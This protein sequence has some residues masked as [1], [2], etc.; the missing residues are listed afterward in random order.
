MRL[1]EWHHPDI[2]GGE[3]PSMTRTFAELAEVLETGD[4]RRYTTSEPANTD[5]RNWPMGGML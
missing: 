5:W 3:M 1:N 4:R 2:L